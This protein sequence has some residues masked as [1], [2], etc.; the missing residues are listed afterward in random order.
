MTKRSTI[1]LLASALL[2]LGA[3]AASARPGDRHDRDRGRDD[4]SWSDGWDDRADDYTLEH[5]WDDFDDGARLSPDQ[6]LRAFARQGY[7]VRQIRRIMIAR[8]NHRIHARA[9]VIHARFGYGPHARNLVARMR[10]R[11]LARLDARMRWVTTRY[12]AYVRPA[13]P[14][15]GHRHAWR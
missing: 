1:L 13:H 3:S 12:V 2:L 7:S 5:R 4:A 6:R 9:R 8:T 11:E 15:R 14:Q 10:A